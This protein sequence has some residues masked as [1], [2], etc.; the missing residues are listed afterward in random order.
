MQTPSATILGEPQ[1]SPGQPGALPGSASVQVWGTVGA[2][3]AQAPVSIKILT[4]PYANLTSIPGLDTNRKYL[5]GWLA[6]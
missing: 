5:L 3:L 1:H 6:G 4:A 2:A